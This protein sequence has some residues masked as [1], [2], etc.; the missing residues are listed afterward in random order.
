[1]NPDETRPAGPRPYD[2]PALIEDLPMLELTPNVDQEKAWNAIKVLGY[3]NDAMLGLVRFAGKTGWERHPA[4]D[5]MLHILEGKT[6]ITLLT[7]DGPVRFAAR[8][9]EVVVI[10]QGLW[11]AQVTEPDVTLMFAT[12]GEGSEHSTKP[13]P[14]LPD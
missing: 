4:G 8:A 6:N 1:M 9:G 7:E 11:H 2:L 10:P 5:E 3:C 13:D 12:P 14:R